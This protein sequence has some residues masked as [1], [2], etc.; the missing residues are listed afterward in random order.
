MATSTLSIRVPEKTRAWL[1][2][3][4]KARGSVGF[5]AARLLEEA[6]LRDEFPG[7]EFRDSPL[8]RVAFVQGTRV[9]VAYLLLAGIDLS[10][11]KISTHFGWPL[12]KAESALA[13]LRLL[14]DEVAQEKKDLEEAELRL[15]HKL[16][17]LQ[18][19]PESSSF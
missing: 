10:S 2:Q 9:Q 11:K 17:H 8:G 12:W 4:A 16:P 3:F 14:P 18:L 19:F 7:V 6:R 1:K 15:L 5:S 13:Y